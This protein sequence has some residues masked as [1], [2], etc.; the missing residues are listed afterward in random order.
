MDISFWFDTISLGWS[1]VYI[2]GSQVILN[3]K[4][5]V[6]L[7]VFDLNVL[8]LFFGLFFYP[9]TLTCWGNSKELSFYFTIPY[10]DAECIRNKHMGFLA[11]FEYV[12][13]R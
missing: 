13:I 11:L 2:E 1:I 8:Y 5:K 7:Y 3:K 10:M 6:C 12:Q 4:L 9:T